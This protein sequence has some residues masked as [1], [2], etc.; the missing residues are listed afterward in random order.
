MRVDLYGA[1]DKSTMEFCEDA[2]GGCAGELCNE[3]YD[4][5]AFLFTILLTDW[6]CRYDFCKKL[7]R[8]KC[9]WKSLKKGVKVGPRGEVWGKLSAFSQKLLPCG[10]KWGYICFVCETFHVLCKV[11][12][13]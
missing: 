2:V 4:F 5:G 3:I 7:K 10:V 8:E 11:L 9:E 1:K 12:M 13:E 6:R